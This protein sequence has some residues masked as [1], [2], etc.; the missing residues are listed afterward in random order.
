[1]VSIPSDRIAI[2]APSM[3]RNGGR[4]SRRIG[5]GIVFLALSAAILTFTVLTGLT[6]IVPTRE[7]V[8]IALLVN[9]GLTILLVGIVV[10]E[11]WPLIVARRRGIAAARLHARIVTLF[12][13]VS[14]LPA[15]AVAVI[16]SVTL[17]I[18]LDRWF[19]ERTRGVVE[20]AVTVARSYVNE[21]A[22]LLRLEALAMAQDVNRA[23]PVQLVDP[24]G[25]QEFV[26][27]QAIL[28][29]LPLAMLLRKD[30]SIIL[31]AQIPLPR[32]FLL[33]PDDVFQ[34][35]ET[36]DA[37]LIAPGGSDQVGAVVRLTAFDNTFLYVS[38]AIDPRVIRYQNDAEAAT[39]EYTSLEGRRAGIQIAFAVVY[40]GFAVVLLLSSVW[41]GLFV[42]NTLVGPIRLL[43]GAADQVSRGDLSVRVPVDP[44]AGD[45]AHLGRTFNTMTSELKSQ[46]DEL[47]A[48]NTVMDARRR[49]TE[50]VLSGVTSG[51]IGLDARMDV[52]LAN[53]AALTLL[54][55]PHDSV[56]GQSLSNVAPELTALL[57]EANLDLKPL[58]QGE[59][60]L[61]R[62]GRELVLDVRVTSEQ[63]AGREHGYVATLDD[64]S[65]L[66]N[67]QRSS[68]W[69][70]VAR[71]IAHEIKNPLTPIQL[72]AERLKR[73]YGKVITV[74]REIFDQ[75][76]DTIV[77][78]VG[79]IGR[80]VDEFS[81]F[82]RMP[83]A[84]LLDE[85]LSDTIKQVVFLMNNGYPEVSIEADLAAE[86]VLARFDRRLISQAA[87]NIVKNATEAIAQVQD[88][89][90]GEGRIRVRLVARQG[91]IAIEVEDN[92]I[93]LPK[94]ERQRLLDPY[95]T[96]REKG[97]GLGLAIVRKILEEHNGGVELL[98]AP[99][100]SV[101]GRGAL[102]R[103]WFPLIAPTRQP[104]PASSEPE[105]A[106]ASRQAT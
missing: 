14:T 52:T 25:F 29:N 69:A 46:R 96:T 105:K 10:F 98:D 48:A 42:A 16:A 68:A 58:V 67:A 34:Q 21:H 43:I 100:V 47:V 7:V 83:K 23:Q 72:S 38:R 35:A 30:T 79:D 8:I 40:S 84:Q 37:V 11:I 74:D 26:N 57:L 85:D 71:R 17:D 103:L 61:L 6:R 62:G 32:E 44:S 49:F 12:S 73:K 82:A 22:Q 106:I 55:A 63:G 56:V 87:T 45:L 93:G 95:V 20:N 94:V 9:L 36:I 81:S 77:R 51:V 31:R 89:K 27:R 15:L 91:N 102:V 33:P 86:P 3:A 64:I 50:A 76:I 18:G 41:F 80:M 24:A 99:S 5:A 97:T 2:P 92:G 70:D 4:L 59:I 19:S 88:L 65:E 53:R 90:P 13:V 54:D 78:Q 66:V 60:K 28:R 1:M 104:Q 75:C 101:G 39:L